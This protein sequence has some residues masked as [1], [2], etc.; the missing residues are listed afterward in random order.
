MSVTGPSE[1]N[2]WL[3]HWFKWGLHQFLNTI[4]CGLQSSKYGMSSPGSKHFI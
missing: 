3:R 2:S 1:Q 4:S